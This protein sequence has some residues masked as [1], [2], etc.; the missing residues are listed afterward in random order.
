MPKKNLYHIEY[1]LTI[2]YNVPT[3]CSAFYDGYTRFDALAKCVIELKEMSER[4]GYE[5]QGMDEIQVKLIQE[6]P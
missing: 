5:I 4:Q 1:S 3:K 2:E 6:L